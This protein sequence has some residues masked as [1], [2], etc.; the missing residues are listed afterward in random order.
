MHGT[1]HCQ[2]YFQRLIIIILRPCLPAVF[3][4]PH[5][6]Q[7]KHGLLALLG[8]NPDIGKLSDNIDIFRPQVRNCILFAAPLYGYCV[9]GMITVR[10]IP[11]TQQLSLRD[12]LLVSQYIFGRIRVRTHMKHQPGY[13]FLKDLVDDLSELILVICVMM[14][15]IPDSHRNICI[16]VFSVE[17]YMDC[18]VKD[19]LLIAL[20]DHHIFVKALK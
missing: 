20:H 14:C 7:L 10:C 16:I 9:E 19:F 15:A 3:F 18:L 17:K 11:E 4:S 6:H 12:I 2:K 8:L 1:V 5:R 13:L